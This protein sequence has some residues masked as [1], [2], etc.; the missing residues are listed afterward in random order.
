MVILMI[1]DYV[2]QMKLF[3]WLEVY[4]KIINKQIILEEFSFLH[5]KIIHIKLVLQKDKNVFINLNNQLSW[6]YNWNFFLQNIVQEKFLILRIFMKIQQIQMRMKLINF[7]LILLKKYQTYKLDLDIKCLRKG[8][9]QMFDALIKQMNIQKQIAVTKIIVR[10]GS[11][12]RFAVLLPQEE[13]YNYN[14]HTQTPPG[15]HLI[16]LPYGDEINKIPT[17]KQRKKNLVSIEML[18]VTQLLIN[19]L[20]IKDFDL[21]NFEDPQLQKFYSHLQ[22]HALEEAEPEQIDDLLQPDSQKLET[23]SE[24]INLFKDC[25]QIESETENNQYLKQQK[26]RNN[27][28]VFS[29]TS[30]S[31]QII[32]QSNTSTCDIQENQNNAQKQNCQQKYN[33]KQI[34][35][36]NVILIDDIR[37]NR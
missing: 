33:S 28:N 16:F 18:K 23:Y 24:M 20:E 11:Q 5:K 3:G 19:G 14:D 13:E 35:E 10:K 9:T 8:S 37:C 15:F 21:R 29:E 31:V 1:K 12:L 27:K 36:D 4:Y 7:K 2:L 32:N 22:A 34:N 26:K 17:L 6:K 25:L 30:E